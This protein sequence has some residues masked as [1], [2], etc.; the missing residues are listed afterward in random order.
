MLKIY[1]MTVGFGVKVLLGSGW[2][3]NSPVRPY[4]AQSTRSGNGWEGLARVGVVPDGVGSFSGTDARER[5]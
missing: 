1:T 2:P 5:G 3:I 4:S